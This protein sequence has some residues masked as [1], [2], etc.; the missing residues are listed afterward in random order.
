ML[1]WG[2]GVDLEGSTIFW[3]PGASDGGSPVTGYVAQYSDD[4]FRTFSQQSAGPKATE[5]RL[6]KLK[7]S[8]EYRFRL[9]AENAA[10]RSNWASKYV[11]GL[12]PPSIPSFYKVHSLHNRLD[13]VADS[14]VYSSM[15]ITANPGN[16][17]CVVK[18]KPTQPRLK[19]CSIKGLTGGKTYKLTAVATNPAG[20]SPVSDAVKATPV[21]KP[22][23]VRSLKAKAGTGKV[24]LTWKNPANLREGKLAGVT[25]SRSGNKTTR[26]TKVWKNKL[27]LGNLKRGKTYTFSVAPLTRVGKSFTYLKGPASKVRVTVR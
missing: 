3:K 4:G 19:I 8:T 6:T 17:R 14:S 16:H 25:Y 24:T 10:G 12:Y 11:G 2:V 22:T 26:E 23:A 27:V 20:K 1:E 7:H 18:Q 9:A 5:M 15:T 21:G 13:A